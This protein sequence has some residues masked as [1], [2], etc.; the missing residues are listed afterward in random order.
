MIHGGKES[1][2]D[3]GTIEVHDEEP[4]KESVKRGKANSAW[5]VVTK[6]RNLGIVSFIRVKGLTLSPEP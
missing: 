5:E 1:S 3:S 4:A 2:Y 6:E